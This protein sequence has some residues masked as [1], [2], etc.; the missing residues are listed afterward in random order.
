MRFARLLFALISALILLS[1]PACAGDDW[2]PVSPEELQM[3][4]VPGAEGAH[5]VILYYENILNDFASVENVYVRIKIL[6]EEGK[7]YAN[8]E[9]PPFFGSN[10][11]TAVK[12]RTIR[13]DGTVVPFDGQVFTKVV[14]RRKR[15]QLYTKAFSIPD[16]Q[17]G[18]IIEYRYDMHD[19][20]LSVSNQ[21]IILQHDLFTRKAHV[22]IIRAPR[23]AYSYAWFGL[24]DKMHP[25]QTR[26]TFSVDV[27]NVPAFEKED[28]MPPEQ[29]VRARL[30]VFKRSTNFSEPEKFWREEGEHWRKGVEL[31]LDRKNAMHSEADELVRGAKTPEEKLR[32]IYDRVQK[33]ENLTY[34]SQKTAK[35]LQHEHRKENN[36]VEDVLKNGYGNYG[37]IT[38]LFIALARGAGFDATVV[39]VTERDDAF[40]HK[41]ILSFSQLN[42]DLAV[43][44]LDGKDLYLSP[45]TPYCPF[46]VIPWEDTKTDGLRV[47][48]NGTTFVTTPA[49]N[50]ADTVMS[51]KADL[52]LAADGSLSGDLTVTFTGMDALSWRLLYRNEDEVQRRK[53]M[54]DEV[55]VWLSIPGSTAEIVSIDNWQS[56]EPLVVKAKITVPSYAAAIGKRLLLPADALHTTKAHAFQQAHRTQPVYFH[57]PWTEDDEITI[58]LPDSVQVES[59]P[60]KR[61]FKNG[62]AAYLSEMTREGNVLKLHRR[63]V[64]NGVYFEAKYYQPLQQVFNTVSA[65]DGEQVVLRQATTAAAK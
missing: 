31:F 11:V 22:D 13:P 34:A 23:Y 25:V 52:T 32:R 26:E 55:K 38:Y 12:A 33:I 29:E 48:K 61:D 63:F 37:D 47:D 36:S 9:L 43:V 1:L 2:Q 50:A 28:Y 64:M 40:F 27:D 6:S 54:Q 59:V 45:G 7:K 53:S 17:V 16:V 20:V 15:F 62:P 65:G 42:A 39:R 3:K 44:K 4:T 10:L 49:G 46:G 51:R 24:G 58:K 60:N 35:E 8:V 5:A 41:N 21:N 14:A 19:P 57:T 56:S 18:S 30:V